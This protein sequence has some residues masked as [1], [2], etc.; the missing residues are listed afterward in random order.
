[1]NKGTCVVKNT[2]NELGKKPYVDYMFNELK[3]AIIKYCLTCT[4]NRNNI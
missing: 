3:P 2:R 1:M 4:L